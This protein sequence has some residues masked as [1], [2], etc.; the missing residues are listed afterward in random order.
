ML[1]IDAL[2]PEDLERSAILLNYSDKVIVQV[3]ARWN[4]TAPDGPTW[5]RCQGLLGQISILPLRPTHPV[6]GFW[7]TIMPGSVRL[8]TREHLFGNNLDIRSPRPEE[9]HRGGWVEGRGGSP[10]PLD[11]EAAVHLALDAVLFEDGGFVGEDQ[12]GLWSQ[13]SAEVEMKSE[14]AS[15]AK[16]ASA[17]GVAPDNVIQQL[18]SYVGEATPGEPPPS[19]RHRPKDH[20]RFLLR[21]HLLWATRQGQAQETVQVL[22]RLAELEHPPLRR[23]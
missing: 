5:I 18:V 13:L 7:H 17:E 9:L 12:C 23:L 14:A 15:I 10:E 21:E 8:L 4:V 11:P 3:E 19:W 22:L 6:I 16:N 20:Q 1:D 2:S